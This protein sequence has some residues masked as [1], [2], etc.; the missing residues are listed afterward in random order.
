[1]RLEER[2]FVKTPWGRRHRAYNP[3]FADREAY[4]FVNYLV[5]GTAADLFKE[6][7]VRTHEAGIPMIALTHDEILAEVDAAEAE[8]AKVMIQGFMCDF[9]KINKLIQV[10]AEGDVVDRWSQAKD[11]K[12]DPG[13]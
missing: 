12:F 5:Q 6:A 9:P 7:V 2:G 11:P 10:S 13:W 8:E 4:K 1:L 3:Q